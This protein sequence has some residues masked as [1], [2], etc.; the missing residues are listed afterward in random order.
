MARRNDWGAVYGNQQKIL[1]A[2]SDIDGIFLGGGTAVQCY[3]LQQRYRESEDLDFFADHEMGTKE[4]AKIRRMMVERLRRAGITVLNEV[5]TEQ[6]T[7]R[8][9][10]GFEDNDEVIKIELLDFTAARYGG[11]GFVT[12]ED[13]PRIENHYN[14]LLYKL[15]ALCDRTDTVKDLF[16]IYFIF[17]T[18]GPLNER[19]M[20]TDLKM[21]FEETTG[22]AY[23]EKELIAALDVENRNWDIVPTETTKKYWHDMQTA[24]DDFRREFRNALLDADSD[25][26]DFTY[27]SYLKKKAAETG[28]TEADFLDVFE[29]NPFIEM[30]CRK[31]LQGENRQ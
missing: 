9:S 21:K 1:R 28:Q 7:H 30:E 26:F 15:K 18:L 25:T 14:L 4:S 10:C 16:D 19:D 5:L 17:K 20:L 29:R 31:R 24:V 13:F 23:S 2:L 27:E 8:I 11:L 12:H 6:K 3:T 22:Y